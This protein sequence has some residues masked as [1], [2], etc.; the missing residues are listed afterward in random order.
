MHFHAQ[1][2]HLPFQT[3]DDIRRTIRHRKYTV[4]TFNLHRHI[5]PLK[6]IDHLLIRV[7]VKLLYKNLHLF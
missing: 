4:S 3:T 1:T 2:V 5:D 6:E 7:S